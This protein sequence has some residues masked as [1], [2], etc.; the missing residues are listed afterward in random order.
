MK[1]ELLLSAFLAA[2]TWSLPNLASAD[3]DTGPCPGGGTAP[4]IEAEVSG[5]TYHFNGSGDHAGEWHGLPTTGEDFEFIGPTQWGCNGLNWNCT[6][7]WT[8]KIKKCQDSA[9]D[10]RIGFQVNSASVSGSFPCAAFVMSGF[11]WYT[12]DAKAV[13]HCPFTDDCNSLIPYSPGASSLV[14]NLG[15]IDVTIFGIPRIAD[16][17]LHNI[18]FTPG[19]SANFSLASEYYDCDD[20]EVGCSIYGTVSLSNATSLDIH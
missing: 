7:T 10:W 1:R 3:W 13:S 18:V 8:N 12:K 2:A 20:T 19:P 15:E 11:P 14:T 4:C 17:H 9:G 6:V 5:T 16:S